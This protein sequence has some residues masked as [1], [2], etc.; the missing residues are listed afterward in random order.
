MEIK[1][2]SVG[3]VTVLDLSGEIQ[4]GN[5]ISY[6]ASALEEA[7]NPVV[8]NMGGVRSIDPDGIG[9]II[10]G[11]RAFIQNTEWRIALTELSSESD[12]MGLFDRML[13]TFETEDSAVESLQPV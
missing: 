6:F 13:L 11:C 12:P 9:M 4:G 2:R 5:D 7:E 1:K 8:L 10:S 3:K